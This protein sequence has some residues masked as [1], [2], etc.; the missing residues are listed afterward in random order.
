[1]QKGLIPKIA[2]VIFFTIA[3]GLIIVRRFDVPAQEVV[4]VLASQNG[5]FQAG[6]RLRRGETLETTDDE[7][8]L[9]QIGNDLF[10]G[11]DQRSRITLKRLW[12]DERTVQFTRGRIEVISRSPIPLT[13]E[14]NRTVSRME[15]GQAIFINYDFQKLVTVAP[16]IGNVQTQI[17]GA[18]DFM[19]TAVPLNIRETEPVEFSKTTVDPTQGPSAPFHAWMD[20]VR[21]SSITPPPITTSF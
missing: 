16:V 4:T 1:M 21:K 17:K 8:I 3:I 11:L 6:Q 12:A 13:I 14:T 15:N 7:F 18:K 10:L 19:L 9:L 5:D 2:G 20:E